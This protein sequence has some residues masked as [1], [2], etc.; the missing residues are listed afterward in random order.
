MNKRAISIGHI[1]GI[2]I[3]LDPSWFLAFALITWTLAVSYYPQD[4]KNW[5][6]AEYWIVAAATSILIFGS[7]V[8]HEVG[9]SIVAMYYK[10]PVRRI[11]LFIFGG[12]AEI[13]AEPPSAK[14]EF[15]IAIAGPLVSFGLAILF[16]LLQ[17][18]FATIAPLFAMVRYLA[19][20]NGSLA[21]FNMI[22]AFP[23]DGGR[24]FRAIL[25]KLTH[26][27][28]KA[29]AIAANVGRFI[30]F[31]FILF[32]VWRMFRGDIMD[33]LWIAF[34]GWFLESAA[35]SQVQQ[36]TAHD[37]LAGHKVS[38]VMRQGYARVSADESLDQVVDEHILSRGQ[39][40]FIVEQDHKSVG[41][42][43]LHMIKEVPRNEWRTTTAAQVMLPMSSVK[44]VQPDSE[45]WDA[46]EE[47]DRDGVNQLPVMA[48]GRCLGMLSR[49]NLIGYLRSQ[50]ESGQT[51]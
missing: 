45:L 43:T 24:I 4:F 22:P 42:L 16:G 36:Q 48:D 18:V 41:L 15:W 49:E 2:P 27:L 35:A 39:R 44:R 12:V 13:G 23:L 37:T 26:S 10:I 51:V 38:E 33:G 20:T 46:L 11:T 29:T 31:L 6:V 34:I 8:L 1:F 30:G 50:R 47:M 19:L 21:V 25:W 3:R 28:R 5:F 14:A 32:G 7:V 40:C 17:S 9:H